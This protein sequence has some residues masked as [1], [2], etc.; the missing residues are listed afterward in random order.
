MNVNVKVSPPPVLPKAG[1]PA[2]A[3]RAPD[4]GTPGTPPPGPRRA[5]GLG[6]WTLCVAALVVFLVSLVWAVLLDG[7]G[8]EPVTQDIVQQVADP[9]APPVDAWIIVG[10]SQGSFDVNGIVQ[11]PK[12]VAQAIGATSLSRPFGVL[13]RR[14]VLVGK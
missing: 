1:P 2:R 13:F 10:V 5:F 9:A 8:I 7:F 11:F 4:R 6:W 12:F 3:Y 14:R